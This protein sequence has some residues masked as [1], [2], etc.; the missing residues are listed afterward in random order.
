M[1]L[2]GIKLT[3]T[4]APPSFKLDSAVI[5]SAH[6]AVS[7]PISD[8]ELGQDITVWPFN[9]PTKGFSKLLLLIQAL[10]EL[11]IGWLS[12]LVLGLPQATQQESW[13]KT[14]HVISLQEQRWAFW[15]IFLLS[16]GCY[17]LWLLAFYP[18]WMTNDSW[19]TLER[20]PSPRRASASW[21]RCIKRIYEV[22][23]LVCP[24]CGEKMKIVAFVQR[25]SEIEKIAANLGLVTWRALPQFGKGPREPR[26]DTSPEF[27]QI[28][29]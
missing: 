2:K 19:T 27:S 28:L 20:E 13:G 4:S 14:L 11:F 18:A 26:L 8:P 9:P 12:F 15:L 22:D 17:S 5:V 6:G 3:R 24:R 7:V 21:A 23:P 16:T 1:A 29:H 10:F 25:L